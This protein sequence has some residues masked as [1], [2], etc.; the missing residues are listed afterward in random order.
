MDNEKNMQGI[1]SEELDEIS[2]GIGTSKIVEKFNSTASK[3]KR[4]CVDCGK[5]F[6][7]YDLPFGG[8]LEAAE[9]H[10]Y[11]SQ[12]CPECREKNPYKP[13]QMGIL[14]N[15]VETCTRNIQK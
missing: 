6:V 11:N 15:G 1:N 7:Y 10:I 3:I 4:K 8:V 9:R 12:R 14:Q 2:G 5:E 13:R